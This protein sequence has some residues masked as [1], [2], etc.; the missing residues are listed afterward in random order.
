MEASPDPVK[1]AWAELKAHLERRCAQLSE[2]IRSYPTPIARCD[3]QLTRLIEER[4]R[5]IEQ[6]K[7]LA[8]AN[9]ARDHLEGGSGLA[10]LEQLLRGPPAF[11]DDGVER[12][13]RNRARAALSALTGKA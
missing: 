10:D 3:E 4:S 11:A 5:G 1:A 7:L 13:I 6:L 2:E 8:E 9:P 12:A